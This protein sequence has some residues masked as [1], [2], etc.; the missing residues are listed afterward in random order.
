MGRT[1]R[2][3]VVLLMPVVLAACVTSDAAPITVPVARGQ[4]SV[5]ISR[6]SGAYYASAVPVDLDANGVRLVS[7]ASGGSYTGPV[8]AGPVTLAATS[9]SSPGRYTVH[10]NAEPGRQYA[11]EISPRNEQMAATF[12]F[13]VVG[14]AADTVAHDETSGAFQITTVAK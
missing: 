10:F 12:V 14:L 1:M 2:A 13:G 11:F 6:P 3:I 7:L 9:W 8:P 4:A 5:K